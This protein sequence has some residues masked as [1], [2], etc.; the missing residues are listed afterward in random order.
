MDLVDSV[1]EAAPDPWFSRNDPSEYII[2]LVRLQTLEAYVTAM[3]D[4]DDGVIAEL[5]F[6]VPSKNVAR[7]IFHPTEIKQEVLELLNENSLFYLI[8]SWSTLRS[9]LQE[10]CKIDPDLRA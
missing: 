4:F 5:L 10:A 6:K 1:F 3:W 8:L 9:D 7:A 2:R